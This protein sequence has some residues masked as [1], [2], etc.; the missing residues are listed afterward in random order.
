M[1]EP[2]AEGGAGGDVFEPEVDFGF[3]LGQAA[4]P[5]ALDENAL[6]VVGGWF[7]VGAFQGDHVGTF[8]QISQIA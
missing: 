5:E 6:A 7:F 3:C 1:G 4:G 2:L 8:A